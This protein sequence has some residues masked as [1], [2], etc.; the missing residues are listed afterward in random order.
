MP[1]LAW[2]PIAPV[3]EIKEVF[4]KFV[5]Q[6]MKQWQLWY[7]VITLAPGINYLPYMDENNR[8]E[9]K[10]D[11]HIHITVSQLFTQL[12]INQDWFMSHLL[13][14]HFQLSVW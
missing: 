12:K 5:E 8:D 10:I 6:L 2:K 11:L 3:T 9:V 14:L 4:F 7:T 13:L 1:K